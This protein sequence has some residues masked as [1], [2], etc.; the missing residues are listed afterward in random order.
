LGRREGEEGKRW[1]DAGI[2]GD[3]GDVRKIRKLNRGM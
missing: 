1:E 2:E 3:G